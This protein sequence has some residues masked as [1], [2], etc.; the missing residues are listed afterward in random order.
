MIDES[1]PD[2][3]AAAQVSVGMLG[4]MT[5]VEIEVVPRYRL[6]ERIATWSFARPARGVGRANRV[7][8]AISHASGVPPG[9]GGP[10]RTRA[11]PGRADGRH[12]LGEDARRGSPGGADAAPDSTWSSRP[13]LPAL[14]SRLARA[15]LPRLEYFVRLDR[16][17]GGGG[18]DARADAGLAA[19]RGVPA[20]ASHRRCR[21][22]RTCLRSSRCRP[23]AQRLRASPAPTTGTI[24]AESDALLG[25]EFDA[26]CTGA[27]SFPHLRAVAR[28]LSEAQAF[29][30]I[31]RR[32]DPVG[33]FLND[34]LRP[35]LRLSCDDQV[36]TPENLRC[37]STA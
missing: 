29:I 25:G 4:V 21:Q 32:L 37:A 24:C 15:E 13:Q 18:R 16:G 36:L 27:S 19:R 5:E 30:L 11:R 1:T 20:R 23:G 9:V 26:R 31:R 6:A 2:L 3:L 28:P 10:I 35:T 12:G 7:V 14:S 33:V 22:R 8:T 34:H 17:E